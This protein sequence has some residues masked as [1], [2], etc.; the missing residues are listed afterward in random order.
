MVSLSITSLC[1]P[2]SGTSRLAVASCHTHL[3]DLCE[4]FRRLKKWIPLPVGSET[5]SLHVRRI[6]RLVEVL[7]EAN[8]HIPNLGR[9]TQFK[10]RVG[11][12]VVAKDQERR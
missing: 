2:D 5:L 12:G 6:L 7:L 3:S 11:D 1:I 4:A 9:R 10:D 8:K